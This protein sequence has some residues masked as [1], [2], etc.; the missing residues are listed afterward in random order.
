MDSVGA[1]VVKLWETEGYPL[2]EPGTPRQERRGQDLSY[3]GGRDPV[4]LLFSQASEDA[5]RA[6]LYSCSGSALY[7]SR[8]HCFHS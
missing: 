3:H 2:F 7:T 8:G 1:W 6:T 5:S 4:I